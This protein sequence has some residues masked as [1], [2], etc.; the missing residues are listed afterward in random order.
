MNV[1]KTVPNTVTTNTGTATPNF[2][3]IQSNKDKEHRKGPKKKLTK[4]DISYPTDFKHVTHVGWNSHKGF[5]FNGEDEEAIKPFLLKAGVS[6][7]QVRQK[8]LMF[9]KR[10]LNLIF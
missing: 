9:I 7:K 3:F 2:G 1:T 4:Q 10:L 5:E 6:E 8:N